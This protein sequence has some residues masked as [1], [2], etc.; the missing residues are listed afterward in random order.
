MKNLTIAFASA[1][2]F[3]AFALSS[4]TSNEESNQQSSI[5]NGIE[6]NDNPT[7]ALRLSL[8]SLDKSI[9]A[10]LHKGTT[11]AA[12]N[13]KYSCS[14]TCSC[15]CINNGPELN[16]T[17]I[18][19]ALQDAS[20]AFLGAA[21]GGTT[22]ATV[23]TIVLPFIGTSIGSAGLAIIG[24]IVCGAA[25]S[26]K[27][28]TGLMVTPELLSDTAAVIHYDNA[29][30]SLNHVIYGNETPSYY[31]TQSFLSDLSNAVETQFLIASLHNSV[32]D[33]LNDTLVSK[34]PYKYISSVPNNIVDSLGIR[35]NY[36]VSNNSLSQIVTYNNYQLGN[37][38]VIFK[39]FILF[40][41]QNV[42]FDSDVD[43]IVHDYLGYVEAS[44]QLTKEEKEL[45]YLTIS[46]CWH[47]YH[48]WKRIQDGL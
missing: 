11:R 2:L 3:V 13:C 14:N 22:G 40:F 47:S 23:G 8:D 31:E 10:K 33:E 30:G 19:V 4:C 42:E 36:T 35:Y 16:D 21:A 12:C 46:V 29:I 5:I 44:T 15:G 32:L 20:G 39:N 25:E 34:R 24:A 45:L 28:A 41:A 27:A 37:K 17:I 6:G 7:S 26:W 1:L 9:L 48:Y 38:G 43:V 18:D